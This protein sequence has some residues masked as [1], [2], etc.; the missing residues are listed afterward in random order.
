MNDA[1][2]FVEFM[3]G[4]KED[5]MIS[6]IINSVTLLIL[7]LLTVQFIKRK[8][9]SLELTL[10]FQMTVVDMIAVFCSSFFS[11]IPF[12]WMVTEESLYYQ[13][14]IRYMVSWIIDNMF[15]VI[16]CVQWLTY[17]KYTLQQS[18]DLLRRW[19]RAIFIPFI[20]AVIIMISTPVIFYSHNMSFSRGNF[21][22]IALGITHFIILFY[23]AAAYVIHYREKKL[24][25][26]HEYIRLT[27]TTICIILS[28]LTHYLSPDYPVLPFF[29]AL[30]LLFADY[31]MYRRLNSIDPYTGLF[32]R[33]YI[34]SLI[35]FV[36]KKK[37]T[38][39]TII[40]FKVKRGTKS[41]IDIIRSWQP[42]QCR[43]ID[44]GDGTFIMISEPIKDFVAER[45]IS[46]ITDHL[47][48]EG[49]PIEA[50]YVTDPDSPMDELL[51]K[52]L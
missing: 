34:T 9:R 29:F 33:K 31:F 2:P 46:L 25:R 27:P 39:A 43:I 4:Y 51:E 3:V 19:N 45:F 15:C 50:D 42:E 40:R 35:S 41:F 26:I 13:F 47:K 20:V 18:R 44:M 48:E 16:L 38:G 24:H 10:F 52:Y 23:I 32:N 1:R 7:I 14:L 30:G 8:H 36:K 49:I 22:V 11:I 5:F 37:Y 17:V 21:Y 12:F 28:L 6:M